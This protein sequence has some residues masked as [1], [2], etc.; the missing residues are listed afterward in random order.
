MTNAD[1]LSRAPIPESPSTVP[2]PGDLVFLINHPSRAIVTAD[3]IKLW[4]ETDPLLSK[5]YCPVKQGWSI[6]EPQASLQPYYRRKEELSIQ[7]GCL[8]WGTRVVIPPPG[9]LIIL[10]Q[11]HDTHPRITR[12]K[13]LARRFVLWPGLDQDIEE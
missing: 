4:T 12:M 10:D 8:L 13:R 7:Q 3:Q 1:A 2:D 6:T 9:R 5:V 11:L